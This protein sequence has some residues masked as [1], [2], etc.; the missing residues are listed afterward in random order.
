MEQ[1]L[2]SLLVVPPVIR[3][4]AAPSKS[5]MQRPLPPRRN[6]ILERVIAGPGQLM[7]YRLYGYDPVGL[8]LLALIEPPSA[9]VIAHGEVRSLDER[10]CQIFVP[11]LAVALAFLLVVAPA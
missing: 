8:G 10:P 2:I 11:V 9:F 1:R 6:L 7:G 3:Q 4:L 5:F